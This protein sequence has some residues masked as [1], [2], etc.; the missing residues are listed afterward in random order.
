MYTFTEIHRNGQ[1]I[2]KKEKHAVRSSLVKKHTF[3]SNIFL[4]HNT[5]VA[6]KH[7]FCVLTSIV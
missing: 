3:A 1:Y 4:E 2:Q 6:K 5:Y 7:I